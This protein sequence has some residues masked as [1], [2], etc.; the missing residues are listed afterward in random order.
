MKVLEI[1]TGSFFYTNFIL[2]L[3]IKPT[4]YAVIADEGKK[5]VEFES[6]LHL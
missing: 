5:N 1:D 6:T 4:L 2:M 3:R